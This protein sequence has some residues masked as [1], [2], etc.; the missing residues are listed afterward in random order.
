MRATNRPSNANRSPSGLSAKAS[1]LNIG[2][3]S[4][5]LS[6]CSRASSRRSDVVGYGGPSPLGSPARALTV[7]DHSRAPSVQAPLR[8]MAGPTYETRAGFGPG[9]ASA[10]RDSA[11]GWAA[12]LGRTLG[13]PAHQPRAGRTDRAGRQGVGIAGGAVVEFDG[14]F[15]ATAS[16]RL[17]RWRSTGRE[18]NA[19]SDHERCWGAA[20]RTADAR[21][22]G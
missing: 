11:V 17:A 15:S 5:H 18:G 9:T 16:G 4:S 20:L 22:R 19:T 10:F 2:P 14:E 21:P 7:A 8:R 6:L 13:L 3:P 12:G 1:G